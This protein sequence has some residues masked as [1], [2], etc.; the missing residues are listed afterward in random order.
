[1]S[2]LRVLDLGN[3]LVTFDAVDG[4]KLE[5]FSWYLMNTGYAGAMFNDGSVRRC[6][7]MHR[8]IMCEPHGCHVDHIDGDKLNN[9]R[10]NLRLATFSQN[11]INRKV[12]NR[13]NTSGVR[14]VQWMARRN[15]WRAQ[16]CADRENHHLGLFQTMEEAVAARREAELRIWGEAAP[17][18]N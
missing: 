17:C 15:K 1:M 3:A 14:G 16:I 9:S 6:V 11:Q 13:N 4:P 18:P 7:L 10:F 5:S 8:L 12:L 2:K